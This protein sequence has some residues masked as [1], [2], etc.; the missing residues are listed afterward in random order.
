MVRWLKA[1]RDTVEIVSYPTIKIGAVCGV[2]R[3]TWYTTTREE[4]TK[5]TARELHRGLRVPI[6]C[7]SFGNP[8]THSLLVHLGPLSSP[9]LALLVLAV[10]TAAC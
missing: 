5:N 10:E 8:H 9:I 1:N 2:D 4:C 3:G 6:A 7:A